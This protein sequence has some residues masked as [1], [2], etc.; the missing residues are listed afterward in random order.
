[1]NR[2]RQLLLWTGAAVAAVVLLVWAFPRAYPLL[3]EP[4]TVSTS[5]AAA[6][7]A[8]RLVDLGEPV[9]DGYVVS[10]LVSDQQLELR[11]RKLVEER[12]EAVESSWLEDEVLLWDVLV[13]PPG[14]IAGQWTYH[15]R[16]AL[17]G[18]VATLEKRI[19]GGVPFGS[20]T[21]EE[22]RRQADAFL[23]AQG[24]D[25]NDFAS[26]EE[27][28]QRSG[29]RTD[30]SLRYRR[31]ELF[32][33]HGFAHG[34][35][36]QFVGD[37][38]AGMRT[39]F[40]DDDQG[41][42]ARAL[43]PLAFLGFGRILAVYV[44]LPL[45]AVPFLKRYHAGE[46]GVRRGLQI[47]GLLFA[48]SIVFQ[49]MAARTASQGVPLGVFSRAQATWVWGIQFA[50][51]VYLPLSLVGF[52]GW[53]VG[54]SLCREGWARKLA[55]FDALLQRDWRNRTVAVSTVRGTLA[56]VTLAGA[57]V[58]LSLVG[59]ELGGGPLLSFVFGPWWDDARYMGVALLLFV[60]I[61]GFY[62]ALVGRLFLVPALGRVTRPWV[63]A[64]VASVIGALFTWGPEIG[65]LPLPLFVAL[66][67]VGSGVL[68]G[69]FL[70]CD[71]LTSVLAHTTAMA[72]I[73][74][75]PL[76]TAA[77]T[78]VQLQGWIAL[79]GVSVPALVGVR[80]LG[81]RRE[82]TYRYDDVP[83]HVRRIAERERQRLELETAR[84]IQSSILPELPPE[85]AGVRLSHAYLPATE[86]GGDFYDVIP[87]DRQPHSATSH[88][89]LAVAVGDVAGHGVSS[90]LVMAAV[91]AALT[92]QVGYDPSVEAVFRRLNR[93]VHASARRRRL[94]TT[95][96]YAVLDPASR[97]FRF[98]SAGHLFPYRVRPDGE[99]TVLESVAYPLGVRSDL[100]VRVRTVELAGGDRIVLASDGVIEATH[101]T[102]DEP[103]GFERFEVELRR[104]AGRDLDDL[105]DAVLGEVAAHLGSAPRPDDL[106]L[107]IL[108][109]P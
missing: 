78:A 83:P 33:R 8:A 66:A 4:W 49:L 107:L 70:G 32:D 73:G 29:E 41:A 84:N 44:F 61:Y 40:E 36:V 25:P 28:L 23:G 81:S 18:R 39:W 74:A 42:Q 48:L 109:V 91:K 92:V 87:L 14:A 64:V 53:S 94:L 24:I 104:H 52:L 77:S 21:S 98:A 56:G 7:A 69:L 63:A 10:R 80:Y 45:L 46:I 51:L 65:V 90:G 43:Q 2:S 5:E 88:E 95:L 68:V 101:E 35:E 106:T 72:L 13:Y 12:P 1:M 55:A 97:R 85:L 11:L 76:I 20:L 75:Y 31:P 59:A 108:E 47:M 86:V 27:R 16:I 62:A 6:I 102:T 3:P 30:L 15:A 50:V 103:F 100:V 19:S 82:F 58:G 37:V 105:R 89:R 26:V 99:V 60:V 79:V 22:A 71:L 34:I 93:V 38:L 9:V 57:L 96:C 67:V 54:E 17:D